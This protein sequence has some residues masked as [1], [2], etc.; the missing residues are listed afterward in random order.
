MIYFFRGLI[1][2]CIANVIPLLIWGGSGG[3]IPVWL[4]LAGIA[5][6]FSLKKIN[7]FFFQ[8]KW[9]KI[10]FTI[11]I[12]TLTIIEIAIIL[13][14]LPSHNSQGDDY[15]I[16][17]G[18]QVR[19]ERPSATLQYRIDAAYEYL[20][21]FK[22][23]KAVLSGGQGPD[24]IMTE[25]QAMYND[26]IDKGIDKER[27]WLEENSHNTRENLI[28][29]FEMIEKMQKGATISVVS[30]SFHLLRA[31]MQAHLLGKDVGTVSARNYPF[32]IFNYYFREF[33]AVLKEIIIYGITYI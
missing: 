3:M 4:T 6:L 23:T 32:L 33:F 18:A 22:E 25:A 9:F 7:H 20:R 30:S 27:L 2:F 28:Y 5:F 17:L 19:G 8:K 1:I 13:V 21:T 15:I 12:F 26:L 14:G 24:E 29:S 10:L 31:K 16:V 11:G